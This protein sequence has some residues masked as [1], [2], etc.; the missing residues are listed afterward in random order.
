MS[1]TVLYDLTD[2]V[3][4]ITL[5]RPDGMNSLTSEMK[6]A[7]V[8]TVQRAAGA[9]EVRAVLI[10]GA[11]RAFCAGQ[12]LREHGDNLAAGKG[13]DGTVERHYNPLITAITTMPKPVVA[14]VNGVAAGAGASLAFAADLV[15]AA[16]TAKFA[17]AF[18]GI[19]LAPDSGMSW[20]LQRLVG[21]AKA[22]E[23][24]LLGT[25]VK[26]A[27]ALELGLVN[28]VV[29]AD[30]L[31]PAAVELARRLASGPTISYHA[32]KTALDYAATHDLPSSLQKEAELQELCEK[33]T[34]HRNATE[35]F[36]KKQQPTFQGR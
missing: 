28:R 31:A 27:E 20:T 15:V 1:E 7:L 12:D 17:T 26:A 22:T 11:G 4:T 10:T 29:P 24:L 33:T 16:D 8:A 14:A 32:V 34:D 36:L 2:G 35:A 18:T 9:A 25:P 23:L 30:E 3:A 21:R 5:N 13:L 19:G 6:E